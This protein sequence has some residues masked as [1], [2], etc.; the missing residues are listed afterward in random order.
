MGSWKWTARYAVVLVV[1][2]LLGAE[3]AELAVFKQTALGTPKLP[4]S[5][6]ARFL[7][8]GGALIIFWI[9]GRRTARQLC[10]AESNSQPVGALV[11]PLT[12]LIVLS[13][14]YD[15]VLAI[16]WPFLDATGKDVYNWICVASITA[17][18]IWLVAEL[19]RHAE[20]IIER[21]RAVL[22]RTRST[23]AQC[24]SCNA[25]LPVDARFCAGCGKAVA[26]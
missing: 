22:S 11:L 7:G 21:L 25:A 4:A 12:T 3:I 6:L 18:A 14:G 1:T 20:S 24:S 17:S 10:S 23:P 26:G 8:Y 2:V 15:V 13:A 16:L 5:A 19:N 9:L